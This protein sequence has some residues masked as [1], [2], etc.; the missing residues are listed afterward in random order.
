MLFDKEIKLEKYNIKYSREA[1]YITMRDGVKIACDIHLANVPQKSRY[2]TILMQTRYWRSAIYRKPFHLFEK[3]M[4]KRIIDFV[5]YGYI[6]VYV[7]VRGTGA[8]FGHRICPWSE[9]EIADM[10]DIAEWIVNQSWSNGNILT[11]GIS[12]SGSTSELSAGIDHPGYKG[13]IFAHNEY[14]PYVDIAFPGGVYNN[15]F[16]KTWAEFNENLDKNTLKGIDGQFLMKLMMKSVSPVDQDKNKEMLKL[17]VMDHGSNLNVHEAGSNANFRDDNFGRENINFTN[18][19]L[20]RYTQQISKLNRPLLCF[21]SWFDAG[22]ANAAINRFLNYTNPMVVVIGSWNHSFE[23]NGDPLL[24]NKHLRPP[25]ETIYSEIINFM[26]DR[27]E[28]VPFNQRLIQYLTLGEGIWKVTDRWPPEGFSDKSL[29]FSTN[30]ALI[31]EKSGEEDCFDTFKI[32]FTATTGKKN[33]WTTE[34]G[35]PVKYKNRAKEDRKLL[36]YTGSPLENTV[37]ITGYPKISCY[38]SSTHE[39]GSLFV[40]LEQ[41]DP[42]G[43]VYYITEGQFRVIH[44]KITDDHFPYKK[45]KVPHSFNQNDQQVLTPGKVSFIEFSL[46]PISILIPKGNRIRVAIAGA[47]TDNFKRYPFSGDVMLKMYRTEAYPSCITL[48][49]N[50]PSLKEV[51]SLAKISKEKKNDFTLTL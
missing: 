46:N 25:A 42:N 45:L 1:V 18:F 24:P 30:N 19:S 38:L 32:D 8:S 3:V 34:M 33:R 7:D 51:D 2:P 13:H 15:S 40:Y 49:L 50:Y 14:D 5:R 43:H 37:E 27:C 48:P 9:D 28:G 12:Y 17:A 20:F 16:V 41:V 4:R 47:D 26:A 44:R 35:G 23:T 36:T 29:Y 11:F 31:P 22:T 39:D 10:N 21:A 6:V